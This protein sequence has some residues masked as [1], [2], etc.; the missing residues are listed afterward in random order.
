MPALIDKQTKYSGLTLEYI[1][2]LME[3]WLQNKSGKPFPQKINIYTTSR[4]NL[5]ESTNP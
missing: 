4:R 2:K 3:Y 5:N 1:E